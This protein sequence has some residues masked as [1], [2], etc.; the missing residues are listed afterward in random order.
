MSKKITSALIVLGISLS[1]FGA[2]VSLAKTPKPTKAQIE[3]AKKEEAAKAEAAKKAAAV[4]SSATKTLNQLTAISNAAQVSYNNAL[5]ELAVA[6]ANA[7]AAA[8][9]AAKTQAQVSK[10]TRVIGKMAA[11]AYKLGGDF[12]NINALLSANGP[13][14]LIDQLTTLDKIGNTNTVALK[15]FKIA[16]AAAKV[17]KIEADRTKVAQ[18]AAT[19]KVAQAKKVADDAK[20]AQQKEVN[21]LRAVQNKLAAE[22][23]KAKNFRVTLEQ[24][25]QLALLE[26]SNAV[27]A[28]KTPNQFKVWP[29][30]GFTGRSTIRSDEAIRT[31]AVAFA[32][33][34]VLARKPYIWGAQGPNAFDCSGLVY[35]AYK[36]AGLGYPSWGRLNAALYFVA[37]KR[38][39]FKDLLP[40]DLL[41]YSYDGSVQNIHHITIYAGNGM[42]WEANSRAVGL[43]YSNMYSIKGL[44]PSGGRV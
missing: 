15:R 7:R 23:A 3:A 31:K 33:K 27:T 37:S 12:T 17:A 39:A 1:T 20:A 35:A 40:G 24:Q 14:D 36:S 26:E 28:T 29:N 42:M 43:I 2:D 21:K 11:S 19:A 9:H 6:N 41:F 25:R 32:K 34:Q 5:K 30:K 38:V 10:T 13:Q 22:L 18:E 4:L 8:I 16:E 44:M